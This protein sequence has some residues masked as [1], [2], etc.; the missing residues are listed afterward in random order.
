MNYKL[1]T[2]IDKRQQDKLLSSIYKE[3]T[4]PKTI[5][6]LKLALLVEGLEQDSKNCIHQR[7]FN[8]IKNWIQKHNARINRN[9][10]I[11]RKP[12]DTNWFLDHYKNAKQ[13]LI[14]LSFKILEVS[15]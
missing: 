3:N 10:N 14:N 9:L 12:Q 7:K 4:T 11:N 2:Y 15:E 1:T 6:F 5:D 8:W 13:Q